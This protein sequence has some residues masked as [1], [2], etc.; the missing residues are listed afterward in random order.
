M[1]DAANAAVRALAPGTGV[2][3]TPACQARRTNSKP[4]SDTSGVPA[5]LMS[6]TES[7]ASRRSST[8]R[9][10]ATSL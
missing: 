1:G 3:P 4:G 5:S 8:R 7:P 2:T 6:A 9:L 10:A